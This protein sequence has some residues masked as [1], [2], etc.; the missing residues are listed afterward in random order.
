MSWTS[1]S[2][3]MLYLTVTS[4]SICRETKCLASG[5]MCLERG[6]CWRPE[7]QPFYPDFVPLFLP[8]LGMVKFRCDN[9]SNFSW[10]LAFNP[11][12]SMMLCMGCKCCCL[13]VRLF[14]GAVTASPPTDDT[15][16]G[17][18]PDTSGAA[19]VV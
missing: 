16:L 8:L 18:C 9:C 6:L 19:P 13:L 17:M 5:E 2:V 14:L 4:T 10:A 11:N 3:Q 7:V 12:H 15:G 1:A